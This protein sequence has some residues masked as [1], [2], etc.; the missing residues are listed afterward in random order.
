[1]NFKKYSVI[2]YAILLFLIS[3][4]I[5]VYLFPKEKKFQY[6][7]SEGS[8][9]LHDDLMAPFDFPIYKTDGELK[10]ER[11]SI[12]ETFIPYFVKDTLAKLEKAPKYIEEI[13]VVW[14]E[15]IVPDIDGLDIN[16]FDQNL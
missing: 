15:E 13:E 11:D 14:Q 2:V 8:P 10:L 6:T 3:V 7:F 12:V 16:S 4:G 5:V 9:W 1:M